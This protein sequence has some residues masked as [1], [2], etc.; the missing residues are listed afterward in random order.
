METKRAY[1]IGQMKELITL[2]DKASEAYYG[3]KEEILSDHEWDDYMDRLRKTEE[4]SGI[5]LPGS[6]THKVS[7]A[8]EKH[9][10]EKS[11]NK[12]SSINLWN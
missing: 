10:G 8:S 7:S 2:L 11:T 4:E 6:P 5:V 12:K 3:G 1:Q 9:L